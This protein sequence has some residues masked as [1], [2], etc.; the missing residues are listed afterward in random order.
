MGGQVSTLWAGRSVHSGRAPFHTAV[1]ADS[2]LTKT[3]LV[4][5]VVQ[6]VLDI[7][8]ESVD[9][10]EKTFVFVYSLRSVNDTALSSH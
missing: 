8:E 6:R 3:T 5:W 10:E 7:E 1:K 4:R 2:H 9:I